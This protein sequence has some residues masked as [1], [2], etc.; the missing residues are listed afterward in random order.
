[1]VFGVPVSGQA[2]HGLLQATLTGPALLSG[3][4]FG[5]EASVIALTVCT[6]AGVGL[7]VFSVKRDGLIQPWW[8]RRRAVGANQ[9]VVP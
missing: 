2:S 4:A 7:V 8:V 1:M 6:A 3:G 5:L 9:A